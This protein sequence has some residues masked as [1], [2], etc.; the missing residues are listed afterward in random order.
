MTA[1]RY[2]A[3]SFGSALALVCL[4]GG[5]Q[6]ETV[7]GG[8]LVVDSAGVR[9]VENTEPVEMTRYAV[10]DTVP[11][12]LLGAG[13]DKALFARI[14]N[15]RVLEQGAIAVADGDF[16]VIRVF[17]RN[18]VHVRD[19]GRRGDGPG[20]FR[21]LS[22]AT[23]RG[24]TV[25]ACCAPGIV[26]YDAGS[27]ALLHQSAAV[28]RPI[29]G[30]VKSGESIQVRRVRAS[31]FDRDRK[32]VL[33]LTLDDT[34]FASAPDGSSERLI[35][36]F[37]AQEQL[38]V[39]D[40]GDNP[41]GFNQV[42][43]SSPFLAT[44]QFAIAESGFYYANGRTIQVDKYDVD[45]TLLA[46]HRIKRMRPPVTSA[47]WRNENEKTLA[48]YTDAEQ[49]KFVAWILASAP[50]LDSLPLVLDMVVSDSEDVWFREHTYP[51]DT[52]QT[53]HVLG[54]DGIY[55]GAVYLPVSIRLR[56]VGTDFIL[57]TVASSTGEPLV[58]RY[59]M[60]R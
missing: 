3:I 24:D 22:Y 42:P 51:V 9:I 48:R 52:V 7:G 17:D 38:V 43:V 54:S 31:R 13:G 11:E 53:W 4:C 56:Q 45:G 6:G 40:P 14:V 41:L 39:F 50:T 34:L 26:H 47:M 46:S 57:A 5:C 20:E 37:A 33:L 32:E 18:G 21:A 28:I 2:A 25:I 44:G 10:I 12:L 19:I 58:A 49:R 16:A 30:T 29:V 23:S 59:R 15:A 60:H 1:L 35:G 36:A 55:R 8:A 27:G